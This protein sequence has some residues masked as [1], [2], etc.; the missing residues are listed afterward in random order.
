[1]PCMLSELTAVT[2]SVY[3]VTFKYVCVA[4]NDPPLTVTVGLLSP[5]SNV[6]VRALS[7]LPAIRY[8]CSEWDF[9]RGKLAYTRR[10]VQRASRL[11][12]VRRRELDRRADQRG[13]AGSAVE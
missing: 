1:M 6:V 3:L 10:E 12:G 5:Q 7:V 4:V 11:W 9:A 8:R 2:T 13:H